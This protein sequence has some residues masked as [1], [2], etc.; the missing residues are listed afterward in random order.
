MSYYSF[1]GPTKVP[2]DHVVEIVIELGVELSQAGFGLI[3]DI[4]VNSTLAL[5]QAM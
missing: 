3:R 5:G 2:I 1:L 4:R